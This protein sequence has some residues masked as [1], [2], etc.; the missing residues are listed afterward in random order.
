[1]YLYEQWLLFNE[2]AFPKSTELQPAKV[3]GTT[4]Y[5]AED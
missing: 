3:G 4:Q 2:L 1:M 5:D